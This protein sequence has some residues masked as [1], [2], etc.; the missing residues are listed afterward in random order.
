MAIR[1]RFVFWWMLLV[2]LLTLA[3]GVRFQVFA[4]EQIDKE[5][6]EYD[7]LL[8]VLN[9]VSRNY[10]EPDNAGKDK[11]LKGAI[12]GI[13]STLDPYSVFL[14]PQEKEDLDIETKG[15]FMGLGIRI[16][17]MNGW[18]T[19]ESPI[20][21]TPAFRMGILS[22][23][24][25]I[26][27]NGKSTRGMSAEDAVK[28][29]RGPKGSKVS[30]TILRQ[31][32]G[33]PIDFTIVRDEIHLPVIDYKMM[34]ANIGYIR[35]FE[36]MEN[37]AESLETALRELEEQGMEALVLDLRFNTGGLLDES[38]KVAGKFLEA[39]TPIVSTRARN[40]ADETVYMSKE[41]QPRTEYPMVLM[42]NQASASASE[43]VAGAL[44]DNGRAVIIG[45]AG[46][47]TFGK[48][49]VQ[50]IIELKFG[51]AIK[52][53][54][55]KYFT[56]NGRSIQD[57]G[58]APDYG[59][60]ISQN[61][62]RLVMSRNLIGTIPDSATSELEGSIEKA[63]NDVSDLS[64]EDRLNEM[65]ESYQEDVPSVTPDSDVISAEEVFTKEEKAKEVGHDTELMQALRVLR[66]GM[67]FSKKMD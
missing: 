10:V 1:R 4:L 61:E 16:A 65:L 25:I 13:M 41:R 46:T 38:V 67:I 62:Q 51:N 20:P 9:T 55:A 39:D 27:I 37:A 63:Q 47:H 11:L 17:V 53:T 8:D 23:D 36:F 60:E 31:A 28:V 29:L 6:K 3:V 58:I 49:S 2:M 35:L 52:L 45:P 15:K 26:R 66:A 14:P 19:V 56:P 43:I 33:E 57:E 44:Q 30:I 64:T 48:A 59:V 50:S 7:V 34:P 40:P 54:T 21:N 12:R 22:G 5:L 42:V 32:E 18:L 24:K